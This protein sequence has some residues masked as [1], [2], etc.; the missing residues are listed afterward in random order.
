MATLPVSSNK[1]QFLQ[2]RSIPLI[3]FD[4]FSGQKNDVMMTWNF[5]PIFYS[6]HQ[7]YFDDFVADVLISL[8][9]IITEISKIIKRF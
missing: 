4:N 1:I 6:I 5:Y 2:S 7:I 3:F 9:E 8:S